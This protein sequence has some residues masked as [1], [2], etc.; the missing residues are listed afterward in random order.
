MSG[1]P[2]KLGAGRRTLLS[3]LC[4]TAVL[5]AGTAGQQASASAPRRIVSLVPAATEMVFAMG[6]GARLVGVSNYDTYPPEVAALPKLGGLLNPDVEHLLAIKPDLVIV[7]AT[8]SELRRQLDRAS[9]PTFVYVHRG[10]PDITATIRALG[11][12]IDAAAAAKGLA[13]RIESQLGAI[14]TRVAGRPRP[15][16]LLVIGRETGTLRGILASGGSGFLHDL[17]ETAGAEDVLGDVKRE[18]VTVS[19][20]MLLARAPEVII[21][22]HYG[23][24]LTRD[25][26]EPE[27]RI[28]SR[29]PSVPAVRT[30]RVLL[31][32][33]NEFVVPGPRVG[34]VAERFARALHPEAWKEP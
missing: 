13:D 24:D 15:K 9:I 3:F 7:Y 18:S 33:G 14:R 20:E 28:W 30:G 34:V 10:L 17:L 26:V 6:A 5:C 4:G 1:F 12:R 23:T 31:L 32:S 8:Q 2:S 21:E 29:V 19:T 22:L 27:R 16:T 25:R 11:D